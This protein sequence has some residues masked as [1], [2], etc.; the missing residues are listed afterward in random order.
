MAKATTPR[1]RII[2]S[3]N[4]PKTNDAARR[5]SITTRAFSL[6][7]ASHSNHMMPPVSE[8]ACGAQQ[9]QSGIRAAAGRSKLRRLLRESSL[10]RRA[11]P[12]NMTYRGV[13]GSVC[14]QK[15]MI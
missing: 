12:P 8:H 4:T 2:Q 3:A 7:P 5:T 10:R 11:V 14:A 13:N 6:R 15:F 1:D 9:D